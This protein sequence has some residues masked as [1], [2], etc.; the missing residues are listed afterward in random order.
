MFSHAS[1][2]ALL[3]IALAITACTDGSNVLGPSNEAPDAKA[4]TAGPFSWNS[5]EIATGSGSGPCVVDPLRSRGKP[6]GAGVTPLDECE[7]PEA[8]CPVSMNV[9]GWHNDLPYS[10]AGALIGAAGS[11]ALYAF[12]MYSVPVGLFISRI[13][14]AGEVTLAQCVAA[15]T[16]SIPQPLSNITVTSEQ[17]IPNW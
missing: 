4:I 10:G 16:S 15:R 5:I 7:S 12:V 11:S 1:R 6:G 9:F 8:P 17:W 13:T 2:I 14:G 3:A